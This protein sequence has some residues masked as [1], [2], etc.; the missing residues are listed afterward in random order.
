VNFQADH[1]FD[2]HNALILP[3]WSG[4]GKARAAKLGQPINIPRIP[5]NL[6][7]KMG[8]PGASRLQL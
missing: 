8:L 5:E 7:K 2:L 4:K 6:L 1:G 3:G